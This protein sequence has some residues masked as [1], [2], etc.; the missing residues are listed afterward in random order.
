MFNH[1]EG[2]SL[3]MMIR[4]ELKHKV[5][6][7]IRGDEIDN[8]ISNIEKLL[9]IY[10]D[11]CPSCGDAKNYLRDRIESGEITLLNSEDEETMSVLNSIGITKIPSLIARFKDGTYEEVDING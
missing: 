10:D 6:T 11:E 5:E 7:T 4:E 1:V 8:K 9:L 3:N 2:K